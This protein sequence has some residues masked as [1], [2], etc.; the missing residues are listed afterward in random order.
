MPEIL[1]KLPE[2]FFHYIGVMQHEGGATGR[3]GGCRSKVSLPL[4]RELSVVMK[5]EG[6]LGNIC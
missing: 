6:S 2:I 5:D 1:L 4:I 3:S